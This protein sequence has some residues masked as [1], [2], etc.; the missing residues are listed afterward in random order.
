[1]EKVTWVIRTF[2]VRLWLRSIPEGEH[3]DNKAA[4][5]LS[6]QLGDKAKNDDLRSTYWTAIRSIGS[7]LEGFPRTSVPREGS[8]TDW[9]S[10]EDI[11]NAMVKRLEVSETKGDNGFLH[12]DESV[13]KNLNQIAEKLLQF[14]NNGQWNG[15]IV[16][17]VPD[18]NRKNLN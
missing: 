12:Y 8:P 17:G 3:N 15:R 6:I 11:C 16:D 4:I 10:H 7:V 14:K 2:D 13:L 9:K 5:K 1:M 18:I